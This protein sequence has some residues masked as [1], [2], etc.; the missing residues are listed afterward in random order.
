M[1]NATLKIILAS[2]QLSFIFLSS[3]LKIKYF[4]F[5]VTL[6]LFSYLHS[7]KLPDLS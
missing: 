4:G 3:S 5:W 6:I 1:R 7:W 2:F